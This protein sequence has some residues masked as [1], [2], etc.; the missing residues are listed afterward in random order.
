MLT[1]DEFQLARICFWKFILGWGSGKYTESGEIQLQKRISVNTPP[2]KK[3]KIIGD[4]LNHIF[5][6]EETGANK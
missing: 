5:E 6:I 4:V 3:R 2:Q 1:V